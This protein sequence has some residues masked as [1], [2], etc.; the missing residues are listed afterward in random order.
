MT[1]ESEKPPVS[2]EE[3]DALVGHLQ[4]E[5]TAAREATLSSL[6]SF[7]LWVMNHPVLGNSGVAENLAA[8]APAL[9]TVVRRLLG[10]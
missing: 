6:D 3:L 8:I 10:M 1:T 9:F 2:Q 7:K 5:E 4:S